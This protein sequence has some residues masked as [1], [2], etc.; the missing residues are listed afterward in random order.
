MEQELLEILKQGAASALFLAQA[1]GN[2]PREVQD[3]L[4]NMDDAGDVIMRNGIYRLS[5]RIKAQ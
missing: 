4:I 2:P 3:V 5:E 1:T